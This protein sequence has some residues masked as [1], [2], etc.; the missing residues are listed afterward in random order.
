MTLALDILKAMSTR[1]ADEWAKLQHAIDIDGSFYWKGRKVLLIYEDTGRLTN[2]P[3]ASPVVRHFHTSTPGFE[4]V[5]DPDSDGV[6]FRTKAAK[7]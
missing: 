7:P 3:E 6:I 5:P 1:L 2:E 4:F